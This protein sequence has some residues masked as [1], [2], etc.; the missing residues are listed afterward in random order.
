MRRAGVLPTI[1]KQTGNLLILLSIV[2]IVP[3]L[4]AL[5]YGEWYSLISFFASALLIF[6]L[7]F[8][9]VKVFKHAEDV[10]YTNALIVVAAGWLGFVIL[11][12]LPFWITAQITPL[13]IQNSFIPKGAS[14]TIPSLIYFK[15]YYFCLI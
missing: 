6:G 10:Q 2:V 8:L 14:Y 15:K 11:G 9:F 7:G 13:E 12:G 5:L 4:I 3:S 1:L